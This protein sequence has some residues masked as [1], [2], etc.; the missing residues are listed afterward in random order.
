MGN[1]QLMKAQEHHTWEKFLT[2]FD[3]IDLQSIGQENLM[4]RH[5]L[6]FV[7]HTDQILSFL[8]ALSPDWQVLQINEQSIHQ[9]ENLYFDTPGFQCYLDH[10][11]GRR[12]RYKFRSRQYQVTGEC[13]LEVK[14]KTNTERTIKIRR[15]RAPKENHLTEVEKEWLNSLQ[16]LHESQNLEPKLFTRYHRIS[17]I[18]PKGPRM[19]IDLDLEME[20]IGDKATYSMKDLGII[21]LKRGYQQSSFGVIASL[22]EMGI[23]AFPISKYCL[24]IYLSH[25]QIKK[26]KFKAKWRKTPISVSSFR[27]P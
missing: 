18:H 23:H 17:L 21:E 10:H 11:N 12:S 22:R 16:Q 14:Q 15:V 6:K 9:Y 19:S 1:D 5:D 27:V 8:H 26:N 4:D 13:F 24:G 25:P 2:K 3:Q 7:L 20:S